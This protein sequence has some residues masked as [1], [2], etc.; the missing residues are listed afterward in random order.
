[1]Y[2]SLEGATEKHAQKEKSCDGANIK[3][4]EL[5]YA[6]SSLFFFQEYILKDLVILES[7]SEVPKVFYTK[8]LYPAICQG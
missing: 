8:A 6:V 4:G 3:N 7:L 2:A 5:F 1:M